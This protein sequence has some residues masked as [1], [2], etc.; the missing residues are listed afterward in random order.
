MFDVMIV[1]GGMAGQLA[2][3][4]AAGENRQVLLVSKGPG[5]LY[6][7][8]GSIDLMG[9]CRQQE[10]ENPWQTIES[11]AGTNHPY[12]LV[13]LPDI[14]DAVAALTGILNR[15][16]E[17]YL[18]GAGNTWL[19]TAIGSRRPGYLIPRVQMA[20]DLARKEPIMLIGWPW[21]RDFFPHLAAERLRTSL[22]NLGSPLEV[23]SYQLDWQP[24]PSGS[25]LTAYDV[26]NLLAQPHHWQALV[27]E[28]KK[29]V[30]PGWRLGLPAVLGT[31]LE[32]ASRMHRQLEHE[33]G[34][35]VF[36]IPILPPS[37]PGTRLYNAL[38]RHLQRLGVEIINGSYARH[39]ECREGHLR[40]TVEAPGGDLTFQGK[41]VILATGGIFSGGI[42]RLLEEYFQ[43][44]I[45]KTR[46][47][48]P[49][50]PVNNQQQFVQGGMKNI[51]LA[52]QMM[53]GYDPYQE[54]SGLGVAAV[55]GWRA[56]RL[57]S[58]SLEGGA[59]CANRR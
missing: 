11:L 37:L 51:W 19:P 27:D 16:Q 22:A 18:A 36:E 21:F 10:V 39:L 3:A 23:E 30:K 42:S 54:K 9:Y 44:P 29:V 1:G 52:G 49:A 24:G 26:A 53:A 15:E 32:Q 41:G 56:G 8:T 48:A 28:L 5:T 45:T 38:H 47:D 40:L 57:A 55:T 7:S 43:E 35:P 59:D 17:H 33:L 4:A 46:L 12:G 13:S 50:V 14:Q 20:G 6:L 25:G 2:A 58:Q 31:T 34:V